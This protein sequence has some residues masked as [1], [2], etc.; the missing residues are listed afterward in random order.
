MLFLHPLCRLLIAHRVIRSSNKLHSQFF[1]LIPPESNKSCVCV[2]EDAEVHPDTMN[3]HFLWHKLKQNQATVALMAPA[4]RG[5]RLVVGVSERRQDICDS[6]L[7]RGFQSVR[8]GC[9]TSNTP[10]ACRLSRQHTCTR[11]HH[12]S[13]QYRLAG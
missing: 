9:C 3:I 4:T 11:A 7:S 6:R 13:D 5:V 2:S 12:A 10:S 8:T 1:F